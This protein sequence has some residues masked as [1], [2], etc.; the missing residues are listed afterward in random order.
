MVKMQFIGLN[1]KAHILMMLSYALDKA[2]IGNVAIV[3]SNDN[4]KVLFNTTVTKEY[5]M[6]QNDICVITDS[7][8]TSVDVSQYE[9]V[10]Y[11][12]NVYTY[13]K[14]VNAFII[15]DN[16]K[17]TIKAIDE[18]KDQKLF[19]TKTFVSNRITDISERD[20]P[21]ELTDVFDTLKSFTK[22]RA[23]GKL[24]G[25]PAGSKDIESLFRILEVMTDTVTTK[26]SIQKVKDLLVERQQVQEKKVSFLDKLLKKEVQEELIVVKV[27]AIPSKD[28]KNKPTNKVVKK[29]T[30]GRKLVR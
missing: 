15:L 3:S 10:L 1:E 26:I 21:I 20:V 5:L 24:A 2:K 19:K 7:D 23:S 30:L 8:V 11:D 9:F 27:R 12:T 25:L 29:T 4:Y 13:I 18:T 16:Y 6:P 28:N 22:T 14:D 17:S